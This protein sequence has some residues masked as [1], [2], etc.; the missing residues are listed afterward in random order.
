M[1]RAATV[2]VKDEASDRQRFWFRLG[3]LGVLW[4]AAFQATL[5]KHYGYLWLNDGNWTHGWL[6]PLLSMY[7]IL[8][9]RTLLS[10]LPVVPAPAGAGVLAVTMVAYFVFRYVSPF[11]YIQRLCPVVALAGLVLLLGGWSV[12]RATWFPLAYLLLAVPIPNSIYVHLTMPMRVAASHLAG[13]FLSALP[14]IH[15]EVNRVI[16]EYVRL[17][18]GGAGRLNVD[19]ACSGM[20]LLMSFAA[21][22]LAYAYLT[23]APLWQ[24]AVIVASCAPIAI[25][26]NTV[27]VT[28]TGLFWIYD[29]PQWATGT[30]HMLTGIATLFIALGLFQGVASILSRLW[31][32]DIKRG[33]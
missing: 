22:G 33:T 10:S 3:A 13:L 27:R 5:T 2:G 11:D 14:S 8:T 17:D 30:P 32:D 20:R 4:A 26:C 15:V 29:H 25:L 16:I 28:A 19:D 31:I 24:K 23:T 1:V 6:I 12:L 7:F 21:I 18:T 9:R